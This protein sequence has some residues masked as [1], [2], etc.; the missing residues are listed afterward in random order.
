ME[1]C[2]PKNMAEINL[3]TGE[4]EVWLSGAGEIVELSVKDG[5]DVSYNVRVEF[6]EGVLRGETVQRDG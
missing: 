6:L 5:I 4:V 1:P 2:R 3:C